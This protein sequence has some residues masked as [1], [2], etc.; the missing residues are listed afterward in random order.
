M[1]TTIYDWRDL[2]FREI[3]CVD[4]EFYPGAGYLN[5]GRN[6]DLITPLCLVALE[7]RS[8]RLVRLW[9]N[10]LGPFPPYRLDPDALFVCYG[11]AAELAVHLACGWGEPARALDALVEF[12]HYVNS[13]KV[14]AEDRDKGFYGLGGALR[15]F[16][17]DD[18]DLARKTDMRDRILQG[19]PFSAEEQRDILAYC[20]D[21]VRAL[22]RLVPHLIPTIRSLPHALLRAKFQ[23]TMALQERRG[24]PADLPKLIRL[25]DRWQ[26]IRLDLVRQLDRPFGCYE[27]VDGVPHWRKKLFEDLINRNHMTWPQHE[28]GALD[29]TD[30]TFREMCGK[31][32]QLEPLRELRY[33]LSKLRLH[34]LAVGSDGRNRTPLW[35]YG[36]KTGRNAPGASAYIFGPAKWLRFLIT[37]PPGRVLVHRDFSQQEVRIAAI[38]SG[39]TTLQEA[40]VSGDVYLGIAE[41]L[42]F[43]SASMNDDQRKAVRALFKTVVLGIQYGLGARSLAIRTGISL[44]EAYEILARLRARF[45]RLEEYVRHVQDHA[46][47]NLEITTPFDWRLQC[48]PGTNPRTI[49]NF[50]IQSTGS[51]ILHTLCV[52][53]E[54]REIKLIA[55]IHDAVLAEGEL[56]DAEDLARELDRLM[57]DASAIVLH[58]YELPS[59]CQIIR[60]GERYFD[61]RGEAMW[62]TVTGLLT[63]L[64]KETA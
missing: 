54:R 12:R 37:P 58:G 6:G 3:W 22:A 15:Y 7:L 52:L 55:P 53:A 43:I 16:L 31:Y 2:P 39:D 42:G 19:P 48:P 45:R 56:A 49:R 23:W 44:T 17:E 61:G 24:I 63:K 14:K 5:G 20:E 51:E 60:P 28:S 4:A 21:D 11:L 38:L 13:G 57:R 1:A 8:G 64:E 36:T 40:C 34:D 59:D 9:Q 18:L 26:D 29:E 30:Q 41:Q 47:L 35:A 27:V 62:N 46:G 33:S 32:P 50:P 10:E 25:R